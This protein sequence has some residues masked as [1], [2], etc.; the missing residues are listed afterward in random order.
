[1]IKTI[2][3]L[4][5]MGVV[6]S[7]NLVNNQYTSQL[8][9][10]DS[11][12]DTQP[13]MVWDSLKNM[14]PEEFSESQKAYYYLLSVSATDKNLVYLD[15]DSTLRVALEYF[16]DHKDYYNLARSQYYLGKY[17][18][19]KQK[20]NQAY[21]LFKKAEANL[22]ICK[23]ED[24]HLYGLIYY[25]L[26]RIQSQH[27]NLEESAT[28]SEQA[29]VKF[30]KTKDTI[31]AAYALKL[32]GAIQIEQKRYDEAKENL[33][34][35][36]E[37]ISNIKNNSKK[38]FE[39]KRSILFT[40][41]SFYRR[42]NEFNQAFIYNN[43]CLSTFQ[44]ENEDISSEYFYNTIKLFH[45]QNNIDSV[46]YYCQ[47]MIT[48]AKKKNTTINLINGYKI[49]SIL[50]EK[51]GNYKEA[52]HLKNLSNKLKDS[53][54]NVINQGNLLEVEKRY[55]KAE[56]ER[57]I[58]K[59]EN[60]ALKAYATI[61]FI[62][63]CFIIIGLLIYNR[64]KKLKIKYDRLS[65]MIKHTEWGF[66]VT[67]EFITEN[68]IAYDE[69]ERM[70]NREKGLNNINSD[71]Y[72]KFHEAL[73]QQKANYSGRLFDRL[74]D[75]DGNFG[76]KFQQL[77]PEFSID[78]LLM[79]SMIHHQWKI[80]DMTTIFHTSID[81]IRKRKHRL[82]HKISAKLKKEIDLDEYLTNL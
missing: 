29:L 7:C 59:A 26:A 69:L 41:T 20:Q 35:S 14:N 53:I 54:N 80:T 48:S 13:Q 57:L 22:N 78:E 24:S 60:K 49:L 58:L 45:S 61:P 5:L 55:N 36:L 15:N 25:Q 28:L 82:A 37:T 72:N 16:Q 63:L 3:V 19:K 64:H 68:H 50:E 75:F 1:M 23:S 33:F 81:A 9:E 56:S 4:A 43:K 51:V 52:C 21:E 62:I 2:C 74:T 27:G 10:L 12:L 17:I 76:K 79:A 65:E 71:L 77:F 11:Q 8:Q 47:Q 34:K 31:S 67:K 73:I 32:K 42:R 30:T 46:R 40:I 44:E 18:Y 66:M 38:Y 70:L 6:A 39:A